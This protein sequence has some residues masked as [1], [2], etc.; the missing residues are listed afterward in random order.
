MTLKAGEVILSGSL[1]AMVAVKAGDMLQMHLGGIGG[2]S[3]RFIQREL[4]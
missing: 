2:A 3:M 1:A 4:S